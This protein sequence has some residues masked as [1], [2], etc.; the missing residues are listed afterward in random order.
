M[1]LLPVW[2]MSIRSITTPP[3]SETQKMPR[4]PP[5]ATTS[6]TR[7]FTGYEFPI[8]P[9]RFAIRNA[10]YPVPVPAPWASTRPTVALMV[11]LRIRPE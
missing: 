10:A 2:A 11:S 8:R 9:L 4:P 7:M 5:R 3:L 1:A 6:P